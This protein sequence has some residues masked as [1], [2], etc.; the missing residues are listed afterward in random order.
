MFR[1]LIVDTDEEVSQTLK[2]GMEEYCG[3]VVTRAETGTAALSTLQSEHLDVAVID[4]GLPDMSGFDLAERAA[5]SNVPVLLVSGHPERQEVCAVNQYPWL[6]K[7][8]RLTTLAVVLGEITT[9]AHDNIIRVH[10]AYVRQKAK[11]GL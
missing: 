6:A 7:P 10:H 8:F 3:A 9:G 1:L 2:D 5:E 4:P 11:S